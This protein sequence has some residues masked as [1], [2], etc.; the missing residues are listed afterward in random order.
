MAEKK[1]KEKAV[2]SNTSGAITA[3]ELVVLGRTGHGQ[4]WMPLF[5]VRDCQAAAQQHRDH[6]HDTAFTKRV[7]GMFR[8]KKR[9]LSIEEQKTLCIEY[10]RD[11]R[12]GSAGMDYR[13]KDLVSGAILE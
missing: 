7:V 12:S 2:T 10:I 3:P 4:D 8:D 13:I 1:E 6:K 11:H 5:A 9:E